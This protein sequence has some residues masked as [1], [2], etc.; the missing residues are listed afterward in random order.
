M[1]SSEFIE[2][3]IGYLVEILGYSFELDEDRGSESMNILI[4]G[5][6]EV[7]YFKKHFNPS[8][9]SQDLYEEFVAYT[10]GYDENGLYIW[11]EEGDYISTTPE[12]LRINEIL[13][14]ARE[15]SD[16]FFEYSV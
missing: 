9:V 2:Q 12:A 15:C 5:C 10:L 7:Y 16:E 1:S 8:Y 6:I 13:L 3:A 4:K 14:K 11:L